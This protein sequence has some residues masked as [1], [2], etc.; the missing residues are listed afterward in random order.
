MLRNVAIAFR[1]K[2]GL[3][4]NQGFSRRLFIFVYNNFPGFEPPQTLIEIPRT[5]H[6]R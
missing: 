1:L 2:K 3:R 6:K 5:G 4:K